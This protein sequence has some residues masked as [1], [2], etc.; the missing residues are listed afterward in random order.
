MILAFVYDYLLE[1][2]LMSDSS[3]ISAQDQ[4]TVWLQPLSMSESLMQSGTDPTEEVQRFTADP[5]P[6]TIPGHLF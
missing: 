1:L 2:G 3:Q 4:G 5:Q 6:D